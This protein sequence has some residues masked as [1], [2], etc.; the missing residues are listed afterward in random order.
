MIPSI[1]NEAEVLLG[2]IRQNDKCLD[3]LGSQHLG[4]VIMYQCHG[5]GGNQVRMIPNDIQ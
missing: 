1:P 4:N 2:E 3:T 5:A